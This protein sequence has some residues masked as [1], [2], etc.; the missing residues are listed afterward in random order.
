MISGFEA[1]L[2]DL[3]LAEDEWVHEQRRQRDQRRLRR[4]LTAL[5]AQH[6]RQIF[7]TRRYTATQIGALFGLSKASVFRLVGRVRGRYAHLSAQRLQSESSLTADD[8]K[9]K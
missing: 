6:L 8:V 9:S 2:I 3:A 1:D 4:S 7:D 5:Q